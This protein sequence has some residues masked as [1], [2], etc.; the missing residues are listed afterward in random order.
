MIAYL[1]IETTGLSR[2]RSELTVIGVAL[3][4]DL[5]LG[6]LFQLNETC[7]VEQLVGDAITVER[8]FA[9]LEPVT[10]LYTYNGKRFDIP[11]IETRLTVSLKHIP[12]KDLMFDCWKHNLKGGLK[13]VEQ[14]LAIPRELPDMNGHM[15]VKLWWDYIN[16]HDQHA[17]HTLLAYN[18]EDVV[19]LHTLRA[20]L[21]TISSNK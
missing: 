13:S 5:P 6:G 3:Y 16:H 2:T 1:D 15:A 12:H 10:Q 8:L 4:E 21:H 11:F 19:N 7:R 17:L 14:Q 20:K 18:K 9:I